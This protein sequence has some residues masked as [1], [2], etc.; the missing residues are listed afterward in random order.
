MALRVWIDPAVVTVHSICRELRKGLR[1]ASL[2][3]LSPVI[4]DFDL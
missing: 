4:G 1:F 2:Q 3:E